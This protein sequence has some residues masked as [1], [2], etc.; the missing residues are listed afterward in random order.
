MST[1]EAGV[2]ISSYYLLIETYVFS[3]MEF[4][5]EKWLANMIHFSEY[6]NIFAY[7]THS[8]IWSKVLFVVELYQM[9]Y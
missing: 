6:I 8:F 3:M 1:Q 4:Y 7:P 5:R 2:E 9:Y